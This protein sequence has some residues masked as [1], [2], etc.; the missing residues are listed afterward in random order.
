[1]RAV[2]SIT[3]IN[4]RFVRPLSSACMATSTRPARDPL[5]LA[6]C[7]LLNSEGSVVRKGQTLRKSPRW[8]GLGAADF[9]AVVT[10]HVDDSAAVIGIML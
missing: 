3:V 10:A 1:M 5:P 6:P 9:F 4:N 8:H 2:K 7:L